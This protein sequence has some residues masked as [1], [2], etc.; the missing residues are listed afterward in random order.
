MGKIKM[1]KKCCT[2]NFKGKGSVEGLH[3]DMTD[4]DVKTDL[5]AV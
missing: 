4:F 3:F 5:C 1:R 2:E